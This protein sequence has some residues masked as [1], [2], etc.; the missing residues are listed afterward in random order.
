MSDLEMYRAG[1]DAV[2]DI[3]WESE[4]LA[5]SPASDSPYIASAFTSA[6]RTPPW[7]Y[8]LAPRFVLGYASLRVSPGH[9]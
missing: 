1:K 2:G 6:K 8:G 7:G 9:Y 3:A 4:H 5:R